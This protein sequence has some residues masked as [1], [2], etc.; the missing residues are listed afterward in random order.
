MNII[1]SGGVE[2]NWRPQPNL[3]V[4]NANGKNHA[5]P[6]GLAFLNKPFIAGERAFET[7]GNERV[8]RATKQR[9][10]S[11]GGEEWLTIR[12]VAQEQTT[13]LL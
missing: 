6:K 3:E 8:E 9:D 4:I 7:K 13:A 2:V 1:T 5:K 10:R 11:I 12:S